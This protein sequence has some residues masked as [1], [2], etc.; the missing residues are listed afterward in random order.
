MDIDIDEDEDEDM[1]PIKEPVDTTSE[2][3]EVAESIMDNVDESV[4]GDEVASTE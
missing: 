3:P 2:A 1:T 4:L